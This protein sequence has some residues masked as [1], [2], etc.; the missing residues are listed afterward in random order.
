MK[1]NLLASI[2]L[3]ALMVSPALAADLPRKAPPPLPPPPVYT[4]TGC[5]IGVNA[6]WADVETRIAVAGVVDGTGSRSANGGA[7]GGQIGCDYQFASS[8]VFGVQALF[9]G[10]NIERE[11]VSVLFPTATFRAEVDGFAT[12]TGRLGY[13]VS[14]AFLIYGKFGWGAY[15]TSLTAFTTLTGVELGSVSRTYSGL[16]LG[17]GGEWRFSPNWSLWV[18]WDRI[19][20]KDKTLFFPALGVGGTTAIV[21]R[22]LDKVLVGVNYRF[23]GLGGP[24]VRAAY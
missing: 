7:F 5:Y 22:D 1:Q 24:V 19:F 17:L 8:W 23:G 18:E 15:K 4:W 10:T 16:D 12:I 2:A 13:A 14:P 11:R 6:G 20:P 9:D 21:R 3:A